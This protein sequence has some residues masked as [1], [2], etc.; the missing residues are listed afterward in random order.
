M[1][2]VYHPGYVKAMN[3]PPKIHMDILK[4]SIFHWNTYSW[5]WTNHAKF[6]CLGQDVLLCLHTH[7]HVYMHAHTHTHILGN[8]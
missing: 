2:N 7:A 6:T 3:Q 8:E 5:K 1:V 4:C